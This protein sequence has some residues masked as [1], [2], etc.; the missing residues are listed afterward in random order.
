MKKIYLSKFVNQEQKRL[1]LNKEQKMKQ[2]Y[3][4]YNNA[5]DDLKRDDEGLYIT[6]TTLA[7]LYKSLG[8]RV[9]G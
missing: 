5:K 9:S 7:N 3:W 6:E 4:L 8:R 2:Y 1:N